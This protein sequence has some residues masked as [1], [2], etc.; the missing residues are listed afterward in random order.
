MN[1]RLVPRLD[2]L[3]GIVLAERGGDLNAGADD[4]VLLVA[5]E[6][7]HGQCR[8]PVEVEGEPESGIIEP[9]TWRSSGCPANVASPDS[10]E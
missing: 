4:D 5:G 7:L 6:V 3:A 2:E 10:H 1:H 9:D 8:R